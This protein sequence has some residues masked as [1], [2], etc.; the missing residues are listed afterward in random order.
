[1]SEQENILGI[2]AGGG[3]FPLLLAEAA[4]SQGMRVVVIAHHGETDPALEDKVDK[5]VWVKLGQLGQVIGALKKNGVRRAVMAGTIAKRRMFSGI[6]PDLKGLALMSRLAIFHDDGILRAVAEE[7]TSNGIDIVPSTFCMPDLVASPG[8]L[9]RKKPAR[10]EKEDIAFGWR[11]AKELGRLDIGQCV[12]VRNKTVLALEAIEGTDET[13]LRGG[14]L[15]GEKAVIIKLS[16]PNQDLRFDVPT[17][18]LRTIET[19]TQVKASVLAVEAGKTLLFDK[20]AMVEYADKNGIVII[21][22]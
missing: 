15:A 4:R 16:K 5:T 10:N 20:S 12:V 22:Q 6:K 19:M 3:K 7:L 11:I 2:I 13:I 1:M 14:R 18:G 21:S 8:R 17:V 9:T